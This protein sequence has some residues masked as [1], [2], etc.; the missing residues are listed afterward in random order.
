M[1]VGKIVQVIGTV[2]DVE[3]PADQLPNLFDAVELDNNGER[4]VLEVQQH[5]GNNWVRCLALGSTDGLARG[6]EVNDTGVKVSVPVG[7]E[8][9]GRLFDVTGT[10]WTIWGR[11][12]PV[13]PGR[14]TVPLRPSR[15]R[16]PP[17]SC[18]RRGSR[19]S[20]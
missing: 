6:T 17:S 19:S 14:F 1:A 4:L 5:I 10:P 13:R 20:T 18:W 15:T 3:F 8:T 16:T 9:L 7:P 12:R 2:V 11:W